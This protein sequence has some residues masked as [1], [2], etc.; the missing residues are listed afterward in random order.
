MK[1][2][3]TTA[4][5]T[6]F[7]NRLI[8]QFFHP[9]SYFFHC[10][11][12]LLANPSLLNNSNPQ[13]AIIPLIAR[14]IDYLTAA[15]VPLNE[16][17]EISK[18]KNFEKLID[19]L[20]EILLGYDFKSISQAQIRATIGEIAANFL[21]GVYQ[22]LIEDEKSRILLSKYLDIKSKLVELM[23]ESNGRKKDSST[24][25]PL[26]EII[27]SDVA[28]AHVRDV[29][30]VE[31]QSTD[32][33][34][35]ETV[36]DG[37][38]QYQRFEQQLNRLLG[39]IAELRMTITFDAD[40]MLMRSIEARFLQLQRLAENYGVEPI[41]II[42]D[43]M[44]Q[45]LHVSL[46]QL[47]PADQ[48]LV[49]VIDMALALIG[50][51]AGRIVSPEAHAKFVDRCNQLLI[52]LEWSHGHNSELNERAELPS[53]RVRDQSERFKINPS[54]SQ[55]RADSN[56]SSFS[57]IFNGF[58]VR[59]NPSADVA[60]L[61]VL[62][63]DEVILHLSHN[64]K[65]DSTESNHRHLSVDDDVEF[66][67]GQSTKL[68]QPRSESLLRDNHEINVSTDKQTPLAAEILDSS[69]LSKSESQNHR[70][71]KR[72]NNDLTPLFHQE[73]DWY[74]KVLFAAL[75]QLKNQ[76]KIQVALEDIELASS[77]LKR[78]ARKFGI[79]EAD[80]LP[81]LIETISIIANQN[82]IKL[83][84]SI[85]QT[86]EDGVALL[87]EFDRNNFEQHKLFD[88]IVTEL[89]EFMGSAMRRL[90]KSDNSMPNIN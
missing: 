18:I 7:H 9:N 45:L 36:T 52:E 75:K 50:Q 43:R 32:K 41:R 80:R 38:A 66:V 74:F 69:S 30:S 62:D 2:L 16:L 77:S 42:A 56:K 78:L 86:I 73:A 4:I 82:L 23:D 22:L 21:R 39:L 57:S 83:P 27:N 35:R 46:N 48:S 71:S 34:A 67:G 12:G 5:E 65:S 1:D 15:N 19:G 25:S 28:P 51:P 60:E 44:V 49:E 79:D 63:D 58:Q 10:V 81:E 20:N 17:R 76:E 37:K 14:L 72:D 61:D 54:L 88:K 87:K 8:N 59:K 24:L 84:P 85:I 90:P 40:F 47:R 70:A 26:R 6:D 53:D 3:T 55:S 29:H 64:I 33:T 11:K 89:K 13:L 31:I 68:T